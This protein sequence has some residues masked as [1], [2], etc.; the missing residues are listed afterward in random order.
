MKSI[1]PGRLAI[2]ATGS[3]LLLLTAC[4]G[5]STDNSGENAQP[6]KLTSA[7]IHSR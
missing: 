6:A 1:P 7:T 5:G 3:A 2:A 4:G